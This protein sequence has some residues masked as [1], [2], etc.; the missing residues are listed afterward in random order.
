[1]RSIQCLL[2]VWTLSFRNPNLRLRERKGAGRLLQKVH[3][4]VFQGKGHST[5]QV[6]K[7]FHM[8]VPINIENGSNGADDPDSWAEITG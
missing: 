1:M 3:G 6:S 2:Y 4:S 7:I 5:A 8:G